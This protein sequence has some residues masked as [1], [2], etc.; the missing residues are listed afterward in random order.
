MSFHLIAGKAINIFTNCV[1]DGIEQGLTEYAHYRL[2]GQ[3]HFY[4]KD[5]PSHFE[6]IGVEAIHIEEIL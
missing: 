4:D 3:I 6:I 1:R 2:N 5:D